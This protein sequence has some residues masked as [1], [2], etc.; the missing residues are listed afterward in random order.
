MFQLHGNVFLN[1]GRV[2]DTGKTLQFADKS[3]KSPYDIVEDALL[4]VDKSIFPMDLLVLYI[5]E[6]EGIPLILGRPFLLISRC[7]ID[8]EKCTLILK[9]YDEV[10]TLIMLKIRK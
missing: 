5:T 6:N 2:S 10:V 4:K 9:V 1:I 3:I 8:I 7:N